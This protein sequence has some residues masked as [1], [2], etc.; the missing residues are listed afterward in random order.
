MTRLVLLLLA[1]CSPFPSTPS[2][3]ERLV[4]WGDSRST[5]VLD[6]TIDDDFPADAISRYTFTF[7]GRPVLTG[8]MQAKSLRAR[9]TRLPSGDVAWTFASML[10]RATGGRVTCIDFPRESCFEPRTCCGDGGGSDCR[11][12]IDGAPGF[13]EPMRW[14][15]RDSGAD[16]WMRAAA[17]YSLVRGGDRTLLAL[18][19]D[20]RDEK[21]TRIWID[22]ARGDANDRRELAA[23]R[24]SSRCDAVLIDRALRRDSPT[25]PGGAKR[26][27]DAGD[28]SFP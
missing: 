3:R 12:G 7:D 22:A 26:P 15:V 25:L 24:T 5:L 1:A 21:L 18:A 4:V 6:Q 23:L 2:R 28:V 16:A 19:D 11:C 27:A 13:A 8:I 14:V 9:G 20:I 17:L 10:C